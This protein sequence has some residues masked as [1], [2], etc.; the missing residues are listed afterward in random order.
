MPRVRDARPVTGFVRGIA[1]PAVAIWAVGALFTALVTITQPAAASPLSQ[2]GAEPACESAPAGSCFMGMIAGTTP[3]YEAIEILSTHGWIGSLN[4]SHPQ[5]AVLW[6]WSSQKPSWVESD[7]RLV[8]MQTVNGHVSQIA[9]PTHFTLGDLAL[10]YA[11]DQRMTRT[12]APP[13]KQSTFTAGFR[14]S[15][16]SAQWNWYTSMPCGADPAAY[17]RSPVDLLIIGRSAQGIAHPIR[18]DWHGSRLWCPPPQ[19]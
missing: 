18:V 9:L 15:E 7:A 11:A 1:R 14:I 12:G 17:W 16:G 4:I 5:I 10:A 2:I 3:V 13:Y 19:P 6:T 8:M